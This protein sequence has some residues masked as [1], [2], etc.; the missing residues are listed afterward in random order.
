MERFPRCRDNQNK[1]NNGNQVEQLK[2]SEHAKQ[3][4]L[5]EV[6]VASGL[7][8]CGFKQSGAVGAR[9][10][11]VYCWTASGIQA[12]PPYNRIQNDLR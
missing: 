4:E 10:A 2:Q 6:F 7:H 1:L 3:V 8:P 11:V 12:R 9:V 5:L